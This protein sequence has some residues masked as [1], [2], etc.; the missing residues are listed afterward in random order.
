[1]RV[2]VRICKC[3]GECKG[4]ICMNAHTHVFGWINVGTLVHFDDSLAS[5][6][7]IHET[8]Q[9]LSTAIKHQF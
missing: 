4:E 1:V 5:V 7:R 9:N 8:S 2:R 3:K 6:G